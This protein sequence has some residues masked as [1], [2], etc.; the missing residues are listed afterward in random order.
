[1]SLNNMVGNLRTLSNKLLQHVMFHGG[2]WKLHQIVSRPSKIFTLQLRFRWAIVV[3]HPPPTHGVSS[4]GQRMVCWCGSR[5]GSSTSSY[6]TS[7]GY[8]WVEKMLR[9]HRVTVRTE[10]YVVR[11]TKKSFVRLFWKCVRLTSYTW[12][13]DHYCTKCVR[14]KNDTIPR[15]RSILGILRFSLCGYPVYYAFGLLGSLLW[16]AFRGLCGYPVYYAFGLLGLLLW[17]AF[18]GL[19]GYPVYYAFGLSWP[20]RVSCLLRFWPFM[21][22]A[23]IL[24]TTLLAFWGAFCG[25]PSVAFAGILSTT[26][27]AFW[28]AFC[29]VP[30][31]AFAGILSTTLLAFWGAFCGVPSVAFAGILSTTLLAFWGA[32]CGV[33]SV[34]FAGI[35]STTLLAFWGAFCG[36]PSVAFAGI[37]STTL[38]AFWGSF[39]GVPSVAFAGILSTTLLAFHGLCGYPVCYAFGLSWP[40]R[41]SCLLRFWPSVAFAGIL[42]T[43]LLAF[44]GAFC[45]VPSV[46]FAGVLSTTLLAFWGSFCG[47]PSVAFAGIL[48]TT[49]LAFHGLCGYPVYYAFG[50]SWPLRVSCLL[51]FWPFGE[52]SV[53]CLPWP[54]RV[55]CLLRFWPFGEPSV[56]C[57]PWPL[58]VSCLLRFW[59][60]GEPSV[61]CLP[62]PL[63]VSCLLR[64]L[65]RFRFLHV[66]QG[67]SAYPGLLRSLCFLPFWRFGRCFWQRFFGIPAAA[68]VGFVFFMFWKLQWHTRGCSV[69]FVFLIFWSLKV[70]GEGFLEYPGLLC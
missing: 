52:P 29:G 23:G 66:L 57:L 46:A 35:L 39:C 67:S 20:L 44:W 54:L 37:L 6:R 43:T 12:C 22:F 34:A 27:L 3:C 38:L 61:G 60:F 1:M 40:L 58:R 33:P 63:R 68:T 15:T 5:C 28:G 69:A 48:S 31:V 32:F 9:Y 26:L 51:R 62:W 64:P 21:A 25:V 41:V 18:R 30:S 56:G 45:G 70:P 8:G 19:C 50:L 14:L 42:S 59:P 10:E 65:R 7:F 4:V 47:V 11:M 17:G 49:L 55:S 24:S 16:G 36:V 13:H 2:V 53:G